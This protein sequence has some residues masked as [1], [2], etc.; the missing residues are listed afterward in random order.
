MYITI[1][2][3]ENLSYDS[4]HEFKTQY[5]MDN[6]TYSIIPIMIDDLKMSGRD[7]ISLSGQIIVTNLVNSQELVNHVE[8]S[9][10]SLPSPAIDGGGER[11]H[12]QNRSVKHR[13]NGGGVLSRE[14]SDIPPKR[15]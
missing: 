12:P 11:E 4:I 15:C 8:R 14:H 1:G 7:I 9:M 13:P 6:I 10:L 2:R 3:A 5:L